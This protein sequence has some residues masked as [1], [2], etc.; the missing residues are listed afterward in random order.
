MESPSSAAPPEEPYIRK[1]SRILEER[2]VAAAYALIK[3][4]R[5]Q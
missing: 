3:Y 2:A 4:G 5:K 1:Q